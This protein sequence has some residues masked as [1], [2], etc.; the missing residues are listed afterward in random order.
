MPS[1]FSIRYIRLGASLFGEIYASF[2][3]WSKTPFSLIFNVLKLPVSV[4]MC[5]LYAQKDRTTTHGEALIRVN[6]THECLSVQSIIDDIIKRIYMGPLGKVKKGRGSDFKRYKILFNRVS[7]IKEW[8]FK[9]S[10]LDW[11]LFIRHK[12]TENFQMNGTP[13]KCTI[14]KL[15]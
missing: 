1:S 3:V 7:K 11:V 12:D 5:V 2:G 13:E 10:T 9:S 8:K 4:C 14:S 6:G 15:I